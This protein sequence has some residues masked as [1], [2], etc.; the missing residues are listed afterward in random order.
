MDDQNAFVTR[1]S[2]MPVSGQ[3]CLR[4]LDCPDAN[5]MRTQISRGESIMIEPIRWFLES[6]DYNSWKETEV[7]ALL[8]IIG[9][10][11]TG[12]SSMATSI[13]DELN[14]NSARRRDNTSVAFFFCQSSN[15]RFRDPIDVLKGLIR[16]LYEATPRLGEH[17]YRRWDESRHSF[18]K[19]LESI[20][21]IWAILRA[22]L[23]DQEQSVTYII[24]DSID[25]C[26]TDLDKLLALIR[27]DGLN[28]S[29][30][31]KWLLTSRP[32]DT[33]QQI[34]L[35]RTPNHHKIELAMHQDEMGRS[36]EIYTAA[37][38]QE[39]AN[40]NCYPGDQADRLRKLLSEKADNTFLW[41]ALVCQ[42]I[43]S[44]PAPEA[45]DTTSN[46]PT[47]LY[48]L[49]DR[50][51]QILCKQCHAG[52]E[53]AMHRWQLL[54]TLRMLFV[55][56]HISELG[57]LAG[58]P[59]DRASDQIYLMRLV[60]QLNMFLSI[61][62][63]GV[64]RFFHKSAGDYLD[65]VDGTASV[66]AFQ[67]PDHAIIVERCFYAME[68]HLCRN[69]GGLSSAASNVSELRAGVKEQIQ[70]RLGYSC[71]YWP[72]HLIRAGAMSRLLDQMQLFLQAKLLSWLEVLS[73][74]ERLQD[75][76]LLLMKLIRLL[77]VS[78]NDD[79]SAQSW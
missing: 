10:P 7:S 46:M 70:G 68:K 72:R 18:D 37:K 2:E 43:Q 12:K 58:I 73:I 35:D 60:I 39:L 25:E 24:I 56:P 13:I 14:R 5:V 41:V 63:D 51:M 75:C 61:T 34:Y 57:I 16:L 71:L 20:H 1:R 64:V 31:V 67:T 55:N 23:S 38:V 32:L 54:W 15:D 76:V 40:R 8:Q 77:Q 78:A 47:E 33:S 42:E 53:D 6:A 28:F 66:V 69:I 22:M 62:A 30:S 21:E 36:V 74:L 27:N 79:L 9:G 4:A 48:Q 45:I 44:M 26:R 52:V 65:D 3:S 50:S 49:Y 19:D 59:A 17:V 29:R 11:G